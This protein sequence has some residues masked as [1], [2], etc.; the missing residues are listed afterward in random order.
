MCN[1]SFSLILSVQE[2][3][4]CWCCW[5]ETDSVS[6]PLIRACYGCKDLDLQWIHQKCID[7]YMSLLP[8]SSEIEPSFYCTRCKD[9]YT[10]VSKRI[11]PLKTILSDRFLLL[12]LTLSTIVMLI[13][14]L[15]SIGSIYS[16]LNTGQTFYYGIS[17]WKFSFLIFL[18]SHICNIVTWVLVFRYCSRNFER[19]VIPLEK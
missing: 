9:T 5:E 10:V 11:H 12:T 17:V 14:T 3:G 4:R 19:H 6:N 1:E 15:D 18:I 13:V 2:K 8:Q 7:Q 16:A